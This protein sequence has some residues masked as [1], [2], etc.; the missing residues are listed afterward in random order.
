MEKEWSKRELW[1]RYGE[2]PGSL[3]LTLQLLNSV[4]KNQNCIFRS[5]IQNNHKEKSFSHM[6]FMQCYFQKKYLICSKLKSLKCLY[7]VPV[8]CVR[9]SV[10]KEQTPF[11]ILKLRCSLLAVKVKCCWDLLDTSDF[12]ERTPDFRSI[13]PPVSHASHAP[14]ALRLPWAQFMTMSFG[15]LKVLQ[16]EQDVPITFWTNCSSTVLT[17]RV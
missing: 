7:I 4:L 3:H 11:L 1:P 12:H 8:T 17:G 10:H 13:W 5:K 2:N 16:A 6:E 15:A 14:V 9:F